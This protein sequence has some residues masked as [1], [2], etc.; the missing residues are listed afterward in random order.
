MAQVS[1]A[2]VAVDYRGAVGVER[3]EDVIEPTF[4][5]LDLRVVRSQDA[6]ADHE[7]AQVVVP[8]IRG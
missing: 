1:P 3:S 2:R 4:D 8:T 6:R 7:L 5:L